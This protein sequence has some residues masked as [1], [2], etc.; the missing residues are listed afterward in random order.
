M[1]NHPLVGIFLGTVFFQ[2]WCHGGQANQSW[3]S[4][5]LSRHWDVFVCLTIVCVPPGC[6]LH[7]QKTHQN[8][9]RFGGNIFFVVHWC[10][11]E[12]EPTAWLYFLYD[13]NIY[14]YIQYIYIQYIYSIYIYKYNIY[15][16]YIYIYIQYI[17]TV[18]IYEKT[19]GC[20]KA[21]NFG[22]GCS[23]IGPPTRDV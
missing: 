5:K 19:C 15:I 9:P 14:I 16:V 21:H 17:Y 7:M 18:Y 6:V 3:V 2:P 13:L 4:T 22:R 20:W 23:E 11:S 1:N 8:E 12:Y 10:R